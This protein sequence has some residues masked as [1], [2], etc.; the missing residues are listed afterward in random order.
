MYLL[1]PKNSTWQ[2]LGAISNPRSEKVHNFLM[3]VRPVSW[4]CGHGTIM[5]LILKKLFRPDDSKGSLGYGRPKK[6]PKILYA[7]NLWLGYREGGDR[8]QEGRAEE[9]G[10]RRQD[11]QVSARRVCH[12]MSALRQAV[13]LPQ[14]TCHPV[15]RHCLALII[16]HTSTASRTERRQSPLI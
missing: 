5:L 6:C 1:Y 15:K 14:L 10:D 7:F 3:T 11:G 4:V 2:W 9:R 8:P 16:A 12:V 13:L